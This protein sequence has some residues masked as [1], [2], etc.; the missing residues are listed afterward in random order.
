MEPPSRL[1]RSLAKSAVMTFREVEDEILWIITA[2]VTASAILASMVAVSHRP[3]D[4]PLAYAVAAWVAAAV[5]EILLVAIIILKS[6]RLLFLSMGRQR[7]NDGF[8]RL[9]MIMISSLGSQR[10][11]IASTRLGAAVGSA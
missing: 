10:G 4:A 7:G 3:N 2:V 11:I 5:M 1:Q 8:N 6:F 9:P